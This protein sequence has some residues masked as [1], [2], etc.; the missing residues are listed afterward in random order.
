MPSSVLCVWLR[1]DLSE[2]GS[3][4]LWGLRSPGQLVCRSGGQFPTVG[5][6]GQ[7]EL[8]VVCTKQREPLGKVGL[9]S[10]LFSVLWDVEEP[11][12]MV[13]PHPASPWSFLPWGGGQCPRC[14]E[15]PRLRES[16][17]TAGGGHR[18]TWPLGSPCRLCTRPGSRCP[19]AGPYSGVTTAETEAP[20]VEVQ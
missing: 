9:W 14:L 6:G 4:M 12:C 2:P 13:L 5:L 20:R 7:S 18:A 17:L 19:S 11:C 8:V 10:V 16:V 3:G 15:K 1:L